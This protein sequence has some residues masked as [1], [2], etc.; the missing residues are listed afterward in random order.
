MIFGRICLL[1]AL[2]VAAPGRA[3]ETAVDM[4][5][6]AIAERVDAY[7]RDEEARANER[8]AD[9]GAFS[10]AV[11]VALDG[12]PVVS[13]AFG[14]ANR[15]WWIANTT[16]TKFRLW[17]ITKIFT[18]AAVMK[19]QEQGRLKLDDSICSYISRCAQ[20]WHAVTVR[21]L[22]TH[23][24]GL[25]EM[26][27]RTSSRTVANRKRMHVSA[28]E[29]IERQ[30]VMPIEFAPGT[31]FVYNNF[32]YFAAGLVIEKVTGK[33]YEEALRELIFMPAAMH[34]T[35]LDRPEVILP[36]RASYYADAHADE[37]FV[38][39]PP[40][41]AKE[42]LVNVEFYDMTSWMFAAGALYSTTED[43]LRFDRALVSGAILQQQTL[44]EMWTRIAPV[45][46]YV[47]DSSSNYTTLQ[48]KA[49]EYGLGWETHRVAGRRC[50]GH[51]GAG[52]GTN[53][54]FLHFPDE[55]VTIVTLT[56]SLGTGAVQEGLPAAVFGARR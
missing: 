50:F 29:M 14:Y 8:Y 24:S 25:P 32:G 16:D 1:V 21:H 2:L 43:L 37:W 45:P 4:T 42:S 9:K 27:D 17:S 55:R 33:P 41:G 23:T 51:V 30:R 11:M 49:P 3:A 7:L 40:P 6:S 5:P 31:H 28:A 20:A 35:G 54:R 34:D 47:P 46:Y 56:N 13:R 12:Q 26:D 10:G 18:A 36:R 44:D 53:T 52:N 39:G 19:L 38:D 15:E 22:L 48:G